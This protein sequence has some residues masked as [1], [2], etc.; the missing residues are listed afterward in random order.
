M[1]KLLMVGPVPMFRFGACNVDRSYSVHSE[2]PHPLG[3]AG[4]SAAPG[5]RKY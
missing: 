5:M 4:K 3:V 1:V 2:D